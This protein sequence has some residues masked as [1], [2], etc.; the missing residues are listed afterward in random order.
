MTVDHVTRFIIFYIN[1][2]K[3]SNVS[4]NAPGVNKIDRCYKADLVLLPHS[5]RLITKEHF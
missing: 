5:V 3:T 4:L 1:N 2:S